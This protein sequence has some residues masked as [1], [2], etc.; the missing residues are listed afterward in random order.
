VN[1]FVTVEQNRHE[2]VLTGQN[3][4]GAAVQ[5]VPMVFHKNSVAGKGNASGK[6]VGKDD[7]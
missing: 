1:S 6:G 7:Q 3:R 4:R 2:I 5:R